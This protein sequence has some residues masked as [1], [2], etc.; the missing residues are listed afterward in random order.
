MSDPFTRRGLIGSLIGCAFGL[1]TVRLESQTRHYDPLGDGF[2]IVN[3]WVLTRKDL[4][5][6]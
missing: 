4:T 5:E 2:V 3:G 1:F 6:I